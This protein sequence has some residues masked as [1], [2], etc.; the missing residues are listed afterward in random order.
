MKKIINFIIL[1]IF[2]FLLYKI[3]INNKQITNSI[4]L[5]IELWKNNIFPILFPFFIIS[6]FLI[7][8]GFADYLS[9]LLKYPFKFLFKS[10]S[11]G[12]FVFALSIISGCPSN[13][14]YIKDLYDKNLINE[15][16]SNKLLMFTHFSNP[17]FILNFVN[18]YIDIKYCIMILICHYITNIIIGIIFRNLYPN[19]NV[20]KKKILTKN[21]SITFKNSINNA[22]NTLLLILGTI[23]FF[24]IIT[25]V[26]DMLNINNFIKIFLNSILELT[27]GI[28]YI[29]NL[30]IL[31][32]YKIIIIT[33]I[34][35]FGGI[36][37]HF[38]VL[39]ILEDIKIKYQLYLLSRIL[40]SIISGIL[41]F[42]LLAPM[43]I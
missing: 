10:N 6:D 17:L 20:I 19:T 38:Q 28:N 3:I 39:S 32:K 7:N 24:M 43:R 1:I 35:S 42:I 29:G 8:Y 25:N 31:L 13:A 36:C 4:L 11:I 12:A 34:L 22:I 40:H 33:M 2:L 15:Y 9:V 5:S 41:I 27:N 18:K 26:I 21:F 23:A 37:I 16:D 14:K 30:N